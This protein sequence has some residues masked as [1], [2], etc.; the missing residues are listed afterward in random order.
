MKSENENSNEIRAALNT[1][2]NRAWRNN[3][4]KL[5]VRGRWVNFGIPGPGGSDLIGIHSL[6]ITPDMIGKRVA[7]FTAIEVKSDTGNP[8]GDQLAFIDFISAMGGIAGVARSADEALAIIS[9]Y[10][11]KP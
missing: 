5:Q 6:T 10:T 4:A 2:K 7:V 9:N 11:P 1:G 8:T 3:I